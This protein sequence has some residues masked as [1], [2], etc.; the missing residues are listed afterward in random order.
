MH[1]EQKE[2]TRISLHLCGSKKRLPRIPRIQQ[3]K[4][5]DHS[6]RNVADL[7]LSG[8]CRGR[9]NSG[10]QCKTVDFLALICSL[11][12]YTARQVRERTFRIQR[13]DDL[14]HEFQQQE[15]QSSP[16]D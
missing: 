1:S 16:G 11:F 15:E 13:K 14:V 6:R 4:E 9:V 12:A 5:K 2:S 8:P 10:P 7:H 3:F